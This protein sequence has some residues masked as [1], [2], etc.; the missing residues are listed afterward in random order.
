MESA[1]IVPL[2]PLIKLKIMTRVLFCGE[3]PSWRAFGKLYA[4]STRYGAGNDFGDPIKNKRKRTRQRLANENA[5]SF[6]INVAR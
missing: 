1:A 4:Q 3:T 5:N 6:S 2:L